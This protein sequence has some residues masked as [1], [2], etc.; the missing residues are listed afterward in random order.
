MSIYVKRIVEG[1]IAMSAKEIRG[2][3]ISRWGGCDA[4]FPVDLDDLI[5]AVR[6][7]TLREA[8]TVARREFIPEHTIQTLE[9][10]AEAAEKGET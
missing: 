9:E 4:A 7:E 8:A 3:M 2:D 10:M 6:A 5:C 1:V